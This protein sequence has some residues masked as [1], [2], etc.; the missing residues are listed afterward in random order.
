[1]YMHINNLPGGGE[2][3]KILLTCELLITDTIVE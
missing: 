3:D 1:M 2:I